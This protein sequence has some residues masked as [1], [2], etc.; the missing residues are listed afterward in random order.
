MTDSSQ[1]H[2]ILQIG[3][4]ITCLPI[5]HGSGDC[6]VEI[7]RVML[8]QSFDCVA[9][10]LPPSFQS[11]VEC[12]ISHL[13]IP[14]M[15]VQRGLPTYARDWTPDADNRRPDDD[16]A[17]LSFVPIDPCQGVIAA[18]RIAM[19]ERL[20]RAFI[21]LETNDF[22]SY[23]L[24]LPDPYALKKVSLAA[25]GAATLP[26]LPRLPEGQPQA[27]VAWMAQRLKAL[28]QRYQ[29]I[30]FICSLTDWPWI[31]EAYLESV[32]TEAENETVGDKTIYQVATDTLIFMM[33]ELPF[34]TGRYETARRELDDDENLTIDGVKQLLLAARDSYRADFRNRA[35]K[36][37]P[38]LVSNCLKYIRNLSLLDRRLS[39]DLYSLVLAAKQVVGDGYALHVAEQAREYPFKDNIFDDAVSRDYLTLGIDRARVRDGD[40]FGIVSRLP[41]HPV[42][43][44]SCELHRR[45]DQSDQKKWRMKWNPYGQCSWPPEDDVI[46]NF[47]LH[48]ADRAQAIMGADLAKT[49]KFTTSIQDGLDIRE[50]LRNWH[51]NDLYV[52][53]LPPARGNLDAVVMLFDS[54]ADP[55]EYPWRST[56]FAEHKNES[57]LGFFA[58]N[59][60]DQMVGPGIALSIYGGALFL[61]PPVAIADIWTDRRL[62]FTETLEQRVLAAACLHSQSSQIALLA[63]LPPGPGW[64]RLAKRFRKKWIHVPLG[65]FSDETIQQLRMVHVLN[66]K[67]VRSFAAEFIRKS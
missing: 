48:V 37:T 67:D 26:S 55:R 22:V 6:A 32:A 56:W 16:E 45:P 3:R 64:R 40:E 50:T 9:V 7:R 20:P 51:T 25:F 58:T 23:A 46:E 29:T 31:R 17:V 18:L 28:E 44:R 60:Q 35:R 47:R 4:R 11:S 10:P 24:T 21:D 61:F 5:I 49:E 12:A 65:S 14:T 52:K 53:V 39:P 62:D 36:I 41:G 43:W 13:P 63:P 33:G 2:P 8:T 38:L 1:P 66:G 15:V 30:L 54:P 42:T 57:T 27:R 19:G 59:F 34:I